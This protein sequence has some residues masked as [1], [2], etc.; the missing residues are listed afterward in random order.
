MSG[1]SYDYLF[2]KLTDGDWSQ[3]IDGLSDMVTVLRARGNNFAA[4]EI[5]S[6]LQ[7]W[8][9]CEKA[10]TMHAR[11]IIELA[12]LV[13]WVESYDKGQEDLDEWEKANGINRPSI[14]GGN[15]S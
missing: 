8:C 5:K 6:F 10:L 3:T 4:D 2:L 15:L 13:E 7:C 9:N 12:K 1:G 14:S 11:R